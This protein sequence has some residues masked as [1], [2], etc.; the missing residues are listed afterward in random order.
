MNTP[1]SMLNQT[2]DCELVLRYSKGL[3]GTGVIRALVGI[4]FPHSLALHIA[5]DL[6]RFHAA[7]CL[8]GPCDQCRVIERHL[9]QQ[10]LSAVV[11]PI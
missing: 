4:G 9:R 1:D 6:G 5:S 3:N 2:D 8:V 7:T 11:K 10:G